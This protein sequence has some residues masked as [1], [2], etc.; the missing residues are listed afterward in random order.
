[1]GVLDALQGIGLRSGHLPSTTVI[2][3][4]GMARTDR[5]PKPG[6]I[7]ELGKQFLDALGGMGLGVLDALG[8]LQGIGLRS[9]HLPSTTVVEKLGMAGMNRLPKAGV[10]AKEY[11]LLLDALEALEGKG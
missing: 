8:A 5:P 10:I 7:A 1:M 11:K 4:L 2:D 6:V 9:G 3:K